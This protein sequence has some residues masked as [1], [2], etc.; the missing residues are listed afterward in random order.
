[1]KNKLIIYIISSSYLNLWTGLGLKCCFG[2]KN[3]KINKYWNWEKKLV[4]IL[5]LKLKLKFI[6][7]YN[8]S[9]FNISKFKWSTVIG[10]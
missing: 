9:F 3:F 1:M 8:E 2:K 5:Y 7:L 6:I 4:K 10:Q